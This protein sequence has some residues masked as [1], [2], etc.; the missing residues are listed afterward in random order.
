MKKHLRR[1][2]SVSDP[3]FRRLKVD[4]KNPG[5]AI[6]FLLS[7]FS[8]LLG[9]GY[10]AGIL[11]AL[12]FIA[13]LLFGFFALPYLLR[14]TCPVRLELDEQSELAFQHLKKPANARSG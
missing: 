13:I 9:L 10:I 11:V 4:L 6:T 12:F 2:C 3:W 7:V 1:I 5:F 14:V 8:V